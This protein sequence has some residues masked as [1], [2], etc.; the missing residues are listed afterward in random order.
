[1]E[2]AHAVAIL[3]H[4]YHGKES[5]YNSQLEILNSFKYFIEVTWVLD[6]ESETEKA[7]KKGREGGKE[8]GENRVGQRST[9]F[10]NGELL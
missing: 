8:R 9:E 5:S 3:L 6:R 2:R 4:Y 7:R 10:G 1:M